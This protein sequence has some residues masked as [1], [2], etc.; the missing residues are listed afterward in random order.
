MTAPGTPA[1]EP[2]HAMA[3]AIIS[4]AVELERK[5]AAAERSRE[6][7][8]GFVDELTRESLALGN[9]SRLQRTA[10]ERV[11]ELAG[12][13]EPHTRETRMALILATAAAACIELPPRT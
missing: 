1:H 12:A 2:G 11:R 3:E 6:Q 4:Y 5:L 10:L 13:N 7:L 9:L 8:A